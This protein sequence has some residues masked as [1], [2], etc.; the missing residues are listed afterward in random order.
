MGARF[1][2]SDFN[3]LAA[4]SQNTHA[5]QY[6][7]YIH[8]FGSHSLYQLELSD[9]QMLTLSTQHRKTYRHKYSIGDPVR[10]LFA[11]SDV[12]LP[13]NKGK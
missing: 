13:T 3:E 7:T 4:V 11:K 2:T 12:F 1:S 8:F 6:V 10:V 5:L 9:G